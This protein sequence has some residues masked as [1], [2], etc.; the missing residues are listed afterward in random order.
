[1]YK[2]RDVLAG[3]CCIQAG[4]AICER[5]AIIQERL[6]VGFA[7]VLFVFPFALWCLSHAFR[8]SDNYAA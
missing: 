6:S 3:P 5:L 4:V 1:M 8:C 7:L 2:S